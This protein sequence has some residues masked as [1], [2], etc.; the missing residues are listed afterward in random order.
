M[1]RFIA[2]RL[3]TAVGAVCC[4]LLAGCASMHRAGRQLAAMPARRPRASSA[5]RCPAPTTT[6]C[7]TTCRRSVGAR[8]ARQA[9]PPAAA[10][11]AGMRQRT[12]DAHAPRPRA[13][14]DESPAYVA[15]PLRLAPRILRLWIKPWEDAD[16]DLYGQSLRLCPD[17]QRPLARRSRA[18]PDPR[19][20]S[21]RCGRRQAAGGCQDARTPPPT[22]SAEAAPPTTPAVDHAGPA[23]A[24]ERAPA[25]RRQLNRRPRSHAM[26]AALRPTCSA[27]PRPPQRPGLLRLRSATT[28][29]PAD[30]F[31]SWLPYSAY[32]ATSSCSSTATAWAS[33]W[34]SC[35]S[36]APTSAWS[37]C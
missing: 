22:P 30:Q 28:D 16:R 26:P 15:A 1:N 17:R 20:L 21:R 14:A 31:A 10:S 27:R 7:R 13:P 3:G 37:R 25:R 8:P 23:R 5:T 6:R 11:P 29:S 32:L 2:A 9:Q 24:A 35:R 34:R 4:A 33:C 18:A 12:G 19:S 36:P